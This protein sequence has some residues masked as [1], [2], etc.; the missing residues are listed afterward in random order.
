MIIQTTYTQAGAKLAALCDK[1]TAN[2]EVVI[3]RR[4]RAENVALI[5][6]TE[7][8][9]LMETACLLPAEELRRE[10]GLDELEAL[11]APDQEDDGERSRAS[12]G[13]VE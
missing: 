13:A 5:S 12:P 4:R 7:L 9:S 1:V 8:T 2:C 6:A 3:I 10:V 11:Y